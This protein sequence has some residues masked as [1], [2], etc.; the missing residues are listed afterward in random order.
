MAEEQQAPQ[1]GAQAAQQLVEQAAQA[2]RQASQAAEQAVQAAQQAVRQVGSE[3]TRQVIDAV[4]TA[5]SQ[6][7]GAEREFEIGKDEAWAAHVLSE[8]EA[9]A[10]NRKRTYDELQDLSLSSARFNLRLSE[11]IAHDS[12]DHANRLRIIAER[13]LTNAATHDQDLAKQHLAHRDIATDR[14]WNV[15]EVA[16]LVAKNAIFQDAIAAAVAAGVNAALAAQKA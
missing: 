15:D 1:I 9:W 2:A 7:V 4:R 6:E 8:S 14:T 13:S 3:T 12:L 11:R 5:G 16:A 10:A